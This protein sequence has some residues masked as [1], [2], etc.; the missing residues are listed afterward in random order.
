MSSLLPYFGGARWP[1]KS[2]LYPT[3]RALGKVVSCQSMKLIGGKTPFDPP[4]Q[5]TAAPQRGDKSFSTLF[6]T[7]LLSVICGFSLWGE[8]WLIGQISV[9]LS[10]QPTADCE[11]HSLADL[12]L[13]FYPMCGAWLVRAWL[14]IFQGRL[15]IHL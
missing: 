15:S 7:L 5:P 9:W 6:I 1:G 8:F 11:M 10:S 13:S 4:E 14:N 3:L 2:K 12:P